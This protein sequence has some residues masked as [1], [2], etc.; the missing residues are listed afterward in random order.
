MQ[1][2]QKRPRPKKLLA[3]IIILIFLIVALLVVWF[4]YTKTQQKPQSI[5]QTSS[6]PTTQTAP[7]IASKEPN[8][9]DKHCISVTVNGDLLFHASLWNNFRTNDEREFDFLPLFA[10]QTQYYDRT[11]L[12]VCDL[13]T[14]V[15]D[16]GDSY[17]DYPIFNIPPQV[18]DA[19]YQVGY[20]ACTTATNHSFDQGTLGISRLTSKLDELKIAHTGVYNTAEKSNEPLIVE[21]PVGKVALIGATVSLNGFVPDYDWQV[22]RLRDGEDRARDIEKIT[23][24]AR[25][26]KEQGAQIVLL[27]LHSVQEYI[28]YADSWQ[29][30]A[31]H[32]LADTGLFDFIYFHGS[33]SVQPIE[34]Y[35][36]IYIAY[37]VGNSV[38]VTAVA[39]NWVNDQG[40]TLRAQFASSDGQNYKLSKLSYLPTFN[41]TGDKYAWCPLSSDKPSGLCTGAEEDGQMFNRIKNILY[42]MNVP[43]DDPVLA[44][45]IV[46]NE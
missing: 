33:H 20:R 43:A 18:L 32:E 42:S 12:A 4:L 25:Q 46:S 36:D 38:T 35:N 30:S 16:H 17:T 3:L 39:E 19:A 2:S 27:Q 41:K 26:A 6:Q 22:D 37:G 24:K 14:P 15:A 40:L 13:E 10:A 23:A 28:D 34:I 44:E 8:C 5:P 1:I 9:P 7:A 45:W 11:D 31:A 29:I 21:L